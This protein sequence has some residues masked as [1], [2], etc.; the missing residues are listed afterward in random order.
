MFISLFYV[1]LCLLFYLFCSIILHIQ[2]LINKYLYITKIT[3]PHNFLF[4]P[5]TPLVCKEILPEAGRYDCKGRIHTLALFLRFDSKLNLKVCYKTLS[6]KWVNLNIWFLSS[7]EKWLQVVT[8]FCTGTWSTYP[9]VRF[10]S[11]WKQLEVINNF[12][13][14]VLPWS[15]FISI[16]Y[17]QLWANNHK[18]K[19]S[20]HLRGYNNTHMLTHQTFISKNC[21]EISY[22]N[23]NH[24]C[25]II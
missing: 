11:V 3:L 7:S 16:I 24:H 14:N 19:L 12:T 20:S 6:S 1:F 17:N 25:N 21:I 15:R 9:G 10:W 13:I 2:E 5:R 18:K 22:M 23:F 8:R 4:K